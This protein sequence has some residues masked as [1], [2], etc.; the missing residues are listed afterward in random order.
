MIT[1]SW[2]TRF[3]VG[4]MIEKARGISI[5]YLSFSIESD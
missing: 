4:D 2:R 3:I 5:L 1:C